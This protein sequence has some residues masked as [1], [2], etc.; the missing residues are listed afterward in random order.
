MSQ[1]TTPVLLNADAR[2]AMTRCGRGGRTDEGQPDRVLGATSA[3]QIMPITK[4]GSSFSSFALFAWAIGGSLEVRRSLARLDAEDQLRV[5][6]PEEDDGLGGGGMF[7]TDFWTEAEANT[8]GQG[9][10][11]YGT[12]RQHRTQ[13]QDSSYTSRD[14]SCWQNMPLL[15]I[16]DQPSLL[17]KVNPYNPHGCRYSV[18]IIETTGTGPKNAQSRVRSKWFYPHPL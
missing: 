12:E 18:I 16:R 4:P 15:E 5:T 3:P 11:G 10:V 9:R 7:E 13:P 6:C 8:E 17:L 2:I 14:I 1:L